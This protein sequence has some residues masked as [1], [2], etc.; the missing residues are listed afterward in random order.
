LNSDDRCGEAI[1]PQLLMTEH[2]PH[3]VE[4]S[5]SVEPVAMPNEALIAEDELLAPSA[6]REAA[7]VERANVGVREP[8]IQLIA[9]RRTSGSPVTA[10]DARVLCLH[11]RAQP[12]RH[13]N[14]GRHTETIQPVEIL[15][16]VCEAGAG[17][18]LEPA[19]MLNADAHPCRR[20]D[21]GECGR[22]RLR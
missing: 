18:T 6:Q 11:G 13:R 17:K 2:T 3:T 12:R 21:V 8:E 5:R 19:T 14:P 15:A 16:V 20:R 22:G 1:D 10:F 9:E 4:R 7:L